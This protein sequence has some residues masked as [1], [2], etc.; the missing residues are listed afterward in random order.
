MARMATRAQ[1]KQ[2]VS[3]GCETVRTV[4]SHYQANSNRQTKV[5]VSESFRKVQEMNKKALDILSNR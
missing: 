2:V 5:S 1:G 3:S 4:P